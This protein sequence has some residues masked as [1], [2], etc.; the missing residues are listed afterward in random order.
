MRLENHDCLGETCATSARYKS[1][2]QEI[3]EWHS[4]CSGA[5]RASESEQL[6]LQ[7]KENNTQKL[8]D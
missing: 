6:Q 8:L 2:Y 4:S 5:H 3:G 1:T 7:K